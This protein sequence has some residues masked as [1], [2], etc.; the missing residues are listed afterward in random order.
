M[1][2]IGGKNLFNITNIPKAGAGS[3]VHTGGGNSPVGWGR[4]LFLGLN[5]KFGTF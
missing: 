3:G 4:T 1:F 2:S 5:Y